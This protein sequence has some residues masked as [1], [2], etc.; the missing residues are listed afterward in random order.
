MYFIS[1]FKQPLV[2]VYCPLSNVWQPWTNF[3]SH[4]LGWNKHIS[5]GEI[6]IMDEIHNTL[7]S[8]ATESQN[9]HVTCPSVVCATQSCIPIRL[10]SAKNSL[11]L[12]KDCQQLM[13]DRRQLRKNRSY[14]AKGCWTMKN[15]QMQIRIISSEGRKWIFKRWHLGGQR[16]YYTCRPEIHGVDRGPTAKN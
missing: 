6:T 4:D 5:L 8:Y 3:N 12:L 7:S 9:S 15:L 16:K 1:V 11:R 14:W 10:M 2:I 13:D